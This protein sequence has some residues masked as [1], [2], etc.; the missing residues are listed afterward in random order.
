MRHDA[1][2]QTATSSVSP[3]ASPATLCRLEQAANRDDAIG[4]HKVLFA[5]FA[6]AHRRRPKRLVLDFDATDV[7]LHG[8][9]EGRFFR[10]YY[11]HYW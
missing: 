9:Q 8:A 4:L 7:P 1:G 10:R 6:K 5:Q 11:D 2:L 3:L